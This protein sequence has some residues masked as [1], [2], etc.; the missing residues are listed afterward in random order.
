[1]H[2]GVC[3]EISEEGVKWPKKRL[4]RARLYQPLMFRVKTLG[5][6]SKCDEKPWMGFKKDDAMVHFT[7][8][9]GH[10]VALGQIN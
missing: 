3:I 10:L 7:F 6:Y 5:F 1:M 4:G 2:G 9:K 8:W